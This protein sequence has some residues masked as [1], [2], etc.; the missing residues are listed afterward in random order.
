MNKFSY[1][2]L[3]GVAFTIGVKLIFNQIFEVE[4]AANPSIP[5]DSPLEKITTPHLKDTDTTS[6]SSVNATVLP[7]LNEVNTVQAETIEHSVKTTAKNATIEKIES[8]LNDF[9]P[10]E[11]FLI[12]K[13]LLHWNDQTPAEYFKTESIDPDWSLSKQ[14]EL[15]YTFY[16]RSNLRNLGTLDSIQC[17]SRTCQ[18]KV[19]IPTNTELKPSDYID[20]SNPISVAIKKGGKDSEFKTVEIYISRSK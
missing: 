2:L 3:V 12:E 5:I 14:V 4:A 9:T 8:L 11:L 6:P 16:E 15:E 20:W 17:K 10:D 1:G 7:L 18:V 13:T 19:Q